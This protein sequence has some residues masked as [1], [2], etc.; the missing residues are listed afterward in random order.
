MRYD[1]LHLMQPMIQLSGQPVQV[2]RFGHF[3]VRLSQ[4]LKEME[5]REPSNILAIKISDPN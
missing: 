4:N 3:K 1:L 2:Q 5:G